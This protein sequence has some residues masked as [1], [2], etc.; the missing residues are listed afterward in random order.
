MYVSKLTPVTK[1]KYKVYL[2]D[3]FAFVL[4]KGELSLYGIQEGMELS[5]SVV[6]RIKKEALFEIILKYNELY[7]FKEVIPLSALKNDNIEALINTLK[8]YLP[9][10][11]KYYGDGNFTNKSIE[12][13]MSEIV[14]E[15][16]FEHTEEEVP[17]S[18][19]CV[20]ES[21]GVGKNN[22]NIR[23][24]VIVD[25]D[26]LKKIVI[27]KRGEMIKKIGVESRKD[28]EMLLNKSV[29]LELFVK[30]VKKWREKEK[31][32]NEF[33]FNDFEK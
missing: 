9:D 17:H 29:Y 3:E 8:K 19:T 15:K 16:V 14:R 28:L 27:G 1:V 32:L 22:Y 18:I 30:T 24:S 31:Y 25:R 11:I 13:L 10:N 4:Y 33:G 7:D 12:F 2:D 26:S 23:I 21:V 5:Q 6:D 20:T